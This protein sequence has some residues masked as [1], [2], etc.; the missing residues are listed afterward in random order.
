MIV[1]CRNADSQNDEPLS[2]NDHLTET[3]QESVAADTATVATGSHDTDAAGDCRGNALISSVEESPTST[4]A[5][6]SEGKAEPTAAA[7]SVGIE[8]DV[9]CHP[10]VCSSVRF[11]AWQKT[12]TWLMCDDS[13]SVFCEYCRQSGLCDDCLSGF[14]SG[15]GKTVKTAK[16][17]LK[18]NIQA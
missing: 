6:N 12:H 1:S 11:K 8:L 13:G 14:V 2:I 10:R 3:V 18:K 17:L 16:A 9:D 5:V 7:S 4:K 15:C